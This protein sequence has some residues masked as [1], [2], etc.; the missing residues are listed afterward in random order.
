MRDKPKLIARKVI[1]STKIGDKSF[2]TERRNLEQFKKC[3]SKNANIM[4]SFATFVHGSQFNIIFRLADLDLN[5]FLYGSYSE[6]SQRCAG[7]TPKVLFEEAWCLA[8][9]LHFLHE[10]LRLGDQ[11][12]SCAHL[13]LKPENILVVEFI[14]S[15]DASTAVGRW[16]ISDFGIAAI[17]PLDPEAH[18]SW[19]G[20]GQQ[21]TPGDVIRDRSMNPPRGPGPFQAPEMQPNKGWRVSKSSDMWSFGCI[22]AMI[23]AFSIGGPEKV[24][25]LYNCRKDDSD[26]YFY[27]EGPAVKPSITEWLRGQTEDQNLKEHWLW[28]KECQSLIQDLLIVHKKD[29]PNAATTAMRLLNISKIG[30]RIL[31]EK[32]KL[33]GATMQPQ[34]TV[35]PINPEEDDS[36]SIHSTLN[37]EISEER[38]EPFHPL[39][40]RPTLA[41]FGELQSGQ[42]PF[43][44]LTV[45]QSLCYVKFET[46]P[47]VKKTCLSPCGRRAAFLST[48]TVYLYQLDDLNDTAH[49]KLKDNPKRID[50]EA[51]SSFEMFRCTDTH[52]WTSIFLVGAYCALVSTSREHTEDTVLTR[53]F[54]Q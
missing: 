17:E 19:T 25:Q 29:R 22:I 11:K 34:P 2:Q 37:E 35:T 14:S 39:M 13:D 15:P 43:R 4:L 16:M 48:N 52:Q 5:N 32:Q 18:A 38:S 1:E 47:N 40:P 46:P 20:K 51:M 21:L 26:D 10:E 27:T 31:L 41:S 24:E 53:P 50:K 8:S 6:F 7:F 23:L 42:L 9:A 12:I 28:I 3:L 30:E 33:W 45:A 36:N 44:P 54:K 49:W